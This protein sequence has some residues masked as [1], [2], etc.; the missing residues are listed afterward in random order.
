[1]SPV[2][3]CTG[4][5]ERNTSTCF[6]TPMRMAAER[7]G[8][9][10]STVVRCERGET[11]PQPWLRPK[12]ARALQVS[13]THLGD[14]LDDEHARDE[15]EAEQLGRVK[16]HPASVD[17]VTVRVF[18]GRPPSSMPAMTRLPQHRSCPRPVT[19]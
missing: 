5:P 19:L 11:L 15:D 18:A 10:R 2:S 4:R 14:L 7:L 1:M 16:A 17:L 3:S 9:G 6:V 12:I 13:A 8:V